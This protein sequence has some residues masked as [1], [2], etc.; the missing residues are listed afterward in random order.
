[1]LLESDVVQVV[2]W[3]M[4]AGPLLAG[5]SWL[6]RRGIISPKCFVY[7]LMPLSLTLANMIVATRQ[8]IL[9]SW[10]L[11]SLFSALMAVVVVI[12]IWIVLKVKRVDL[13]EPDK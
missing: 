8:P 2:L 11:R 1:M 4:I 9:S 12:P 3:V 7:V 13:T 10:T 6:S 5:G